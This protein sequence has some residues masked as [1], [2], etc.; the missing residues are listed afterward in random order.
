MY[1]SEFVIFTRFLSFISLAYVALRYKTSQHSCLSVNFSK[2]S[3][4]SSFE[5]TSDDPAV[6]LSS[7]EDAEDPGESIGDPAVKLSSKGDSS[8]GDSVVK[9]SSVQNLS[10][11]PA[12]K[13]SSGQVL[14]DPTGKFSICQEQDTSV[15]PTGKLKS[16][17]DNGF[18]P[19]G[20]LSSCEDTIGCPTGKLNVWNDTSGEVTS[21]VLERL[22]CAEQVIH[23]NGVKHKSVIP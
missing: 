19:T 10:S 21:T 8:N 11:N 22:E 5:D 7:C 14:S 4:L 23:F 12:L 13:L 3:R 17:E 9:L 2:S 6:K 16:W 18:Y 1:F 15:D 20:K